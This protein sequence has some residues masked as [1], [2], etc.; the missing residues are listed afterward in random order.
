MKR[1]VYFKGS[2]RLLL[3]EEANEFHQ[4]RQDRRRTEVMKR[5]LQSKRSMIC[6]IGMGIE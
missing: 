2:A 1:Q 4:Y 5:G 6:G 3:I